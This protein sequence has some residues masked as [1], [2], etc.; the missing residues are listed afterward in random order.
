MVTGI[1]VTNYRM[2]TD[3]IYVCCII[4]SINRKPGVLLA[5]QA[6]LQSD[7]VVYE[8]G[9]ELETRSFASRAESVF[10]ETASYTS[11]VRR[12]NPLDL[13]VAQNQVDK[14]QNGKVMSH[15]DGY[16]TNTLMTACHVVAKLRHR[17][18][19][20]FIFYYDYYRLEINCFIRRGILDKFRSNRNALYL[21]L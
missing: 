15:S 18:N 2:F 14:R 17:Q 11:R 19:Y 8:Q 3:C 13:Q 12:R 5:V 1:S 16:W 6:Q 10:N 21:I 4:L 7:C 9:R 20:L